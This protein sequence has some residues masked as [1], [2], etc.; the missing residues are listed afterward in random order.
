M[1]RIE[2]TM[3]FETVGESLWERHRA[4]FPVTK[5]LIYLNHAAVGAPRFP[6]RRHCHALAGDRCRGVWQPP[7]RQVDGLLRRP[8]CRSGEDVQIPT[9]AKLPS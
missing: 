9:P 2:D 1:L 3:G 4:D 5:S 7:L 8:P 6:G